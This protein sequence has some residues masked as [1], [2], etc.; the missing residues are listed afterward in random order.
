MPMI[1]LSKLLIPEG[2]SERLYR[3]LRDTVKAEIIPALE[4]AGFAQ[5]ENPMCPKPSARTKVYNPHGLFRRGRAGHDDLIE[6]VYDDWSYPEFYLI[7]GVAPYEGV[8]VW[9]KPFP[10][11]R[12]GT[13]ESPELF[14][15]SSS[16]RSFRPFLLLWP[17]QDER[18]IPRVVD[19]AVKLLP[20]VFDW[21]DN[22]VVGPNLFGGR[23][24]DSVDRAL[25]DT[26][27]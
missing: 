21:F 24:D 17:F 4:Q 18:N 9:G 23:N 3:D 26:K 27:S 5:G 10:Y 13:S 8:I 20:Q 1:W 25:D 12:M 11:E 16:V 19:H 6:I 2:R 15:L 14:S 22:G 7:L